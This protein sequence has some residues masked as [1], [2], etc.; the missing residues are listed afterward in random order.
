MDRIFRIGKVTKINGNEVKV[1]F[2]DVNIESDWLKIVH[3]C[4]QK[5]GCSYNCKYSVGD[6]VL[7]AYNPGF[8]EQGFVLGVLL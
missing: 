1:H 3:I 7:C 8:N 6:Y 2:E 5:C 4:K